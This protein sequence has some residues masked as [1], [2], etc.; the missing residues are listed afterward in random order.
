MLTASWIARQHQQWATDYDA[1]VAELE[2]DA[3]FDAPSLASA[4]ADGANDS[5]AVDSALF[6]SRT[7]AECL[8]D[9]YTAPACETDVNKN[10]QGALTSCAAAPTASPPRRRLFAQQLA[11]TRPTVEDAAMRHSLE[12]SSG[13]SLFRHVL[14]TRSRNQVSH[15]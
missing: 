4:V 3:D 9:S 12:M 2:F 10:G 14:R 8:V 15:W 6:I 1:N 11:L 5:A 7:G 13:E